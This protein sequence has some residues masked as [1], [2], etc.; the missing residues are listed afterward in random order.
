MSQEALDSAMALFVVNQARL[1]A[2]QT[3]ELRIAE[4]NALRKRLS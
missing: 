2:L 3:P 1:N 4:A